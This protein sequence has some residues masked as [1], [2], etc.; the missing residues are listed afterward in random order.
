MQQHAV[1]TYKEAAHFLRV[2]ERTLRN[3][4]DQGK[5]SPSRIGERRAVFLRK[6]LDRFLEDSMK[7]PHA[8]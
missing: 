6:E 7:R 2:T 1:F 5:L 8:A 4:V 3:W